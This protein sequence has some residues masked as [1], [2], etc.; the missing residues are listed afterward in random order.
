MIGPLANPYLEL[1]SGSTIL[2]MNDNWMDNLTGGSQEVAIQNTG[3]APTNA[4]ESAILAVLNPGAYTAILSGTIN[5]TGED[6]VE[7][8]NHAAAGQGGRDLVT[9]QRSEPC[10]G[11]LMTIGKKG[12]KYEI[13]EKIGEG[14][15]GIVFKARDLSLHRFVA[16][17]FLPPEITASVGRDNL[18][19]TQFHPEKSQVTGFRLIANFLRWKP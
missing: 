18:A 15:M 8:D 4:L 9:L 7:A 2:A 1:H 19:G 5:G 6:R 3:V 11:G 12:C 10:G 16:L 17:K 13:V 14:G